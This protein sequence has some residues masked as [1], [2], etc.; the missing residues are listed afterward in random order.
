MSTPQWLRA[1]EIPKDCI[2]PTSSAQERRRSFSIHPQE[3]DSVWRVKVDGCWLQ[4]SDEK[5][6]DYLFWGQSASGRRVILLVELK[7]QNFGKALEQMKSTLQRLC[8]R[9]GSSGIHTG[10]HQSS[11]G[12]D[13][14]ATGGVR[15]YVVL[16]KGRGVPQRQRER[17][18]IRRRYG[19]LVYPKSQ[20]LE[21]NGLDAL[22]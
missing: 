19:V 16:S 13:L 21:I 10:S 11:P 2:S 14:H 9:A 1:L 5:K 8:K 20:R 17:E 12:H 3:G 7:G 15:A 18:R 4:S 22:P 6:V